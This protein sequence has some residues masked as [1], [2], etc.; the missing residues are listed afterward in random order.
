[1]REH[2][3]L[4]EVMATGKLL[5]FAGR[6]AAASMDFFPESFRLLAEEFK[7]WRPDLV[8]TSPL[9]AFECHALAGVY[10]IPC[11]RAMLQW[12]Y[13]LVQDMM[14]EMRRFALWSAE[15]KGKSSVILKQLPECDLFTS[16]SFS[17]FL[18]HTMQPLVLTLVGFSPYL[19]NNSEFARS[20]KQQQNKFTGFWVLDGEKQE[21]QHN[22]DDPEFGGD[23]AQNVKEFWQKGPFVY[24]GF[25]SMISVS[26]N[27]MTCLAVRALM[28]SKLRGI[29]LGGYASLGP[30]FLEGHRD[31]DAMISYVRENVLFVQSAP[32]EWLFP[33][34]S[35]IVHHGGVG[36][37]AAALRSGT[38][39]VVVPCGFDQFDNAAMVQ[40]SGAGIAL[41]QLSKV[42]VKT[43]S[44]AMQACVSDVRMIQAA[45]NLASRLLAED[46]LER[47][48]EEVISVF[49]T[50]VDTGV[51]RRRFEMRKRDILLLRS[52][53]ARCWSW[54]PCICRWN[55]T[56]STIRSSQPVSTADTRLPL[57]LSAKISDGAH[58]VGV[59]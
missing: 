15:A 58:Y 8:V 17:E 23:A 19:F 41:K 32:H 16:Q 37:T 54:I 3:T 18:L 45:R 36:T 47:A 55:A 22:K 59:K 29:I 52:R 39:S 21:H 7:L 48:V 4:R 44:R 5:K 57:L 43:L 31:T 35:A 30:A 34:C 26:A 28:V 20:P 40:Q 53:K 6:L 27:F 42:T 14:V 10:G 51:W 2:P 33:K 11:M 50:D 9:C 1:M 12:K 46:G 24:I 56:T 13:C 38:P 49:K 25:G